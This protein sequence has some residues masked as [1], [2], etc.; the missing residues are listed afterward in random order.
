LVQIAIKTGELL[1]RRPEWL[2][3]VHDHTPQD[4][5]A[6]LD[7]RIHEVPLAAIGV[8]RQEQNVA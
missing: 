8:G 5:L 2:A 3:A 4:V 6:T 7:A 1:R